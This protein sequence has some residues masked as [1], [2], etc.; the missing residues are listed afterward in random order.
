MTATCAEGETSDMLV[1]AVIE[2]PDDTVIDN[3]LPAKVSYMSYESDGV[4]SKQAEG[5]LE[6][7]RELIKEGAEMIAVK[8][9]EGD[10]ILFKYPDDTPPEDARLMSDILKAEFP[11]NK[12][13]GITKN[14]DLLVENVD[15]AVAMLEKM[16]AHIKV[17]A[18]T[19]KKIILQ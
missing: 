13:L 4:V 10:V 3:R 11:N 19:Q 1:H 6:P 14:V 8:L 15:E 7:L 18:G 9:Q 5:Y 2:I 12:V 17:T 16:I